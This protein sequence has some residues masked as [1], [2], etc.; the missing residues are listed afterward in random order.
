M[1]IGTEPTALMLHPAALQDLPEKFQGVFWFSTDPSP[2]LC[3]NF[4]GGAFNA[5]TR[6]P[7]GKGNEKCKK[8]RNEFLLPS[9]AYIS[10]LGSA[11]LNSSI[12]TVVT[13][14]LQQ[15]ML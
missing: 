8:G 7:L 3:L 1:V 12:S 15:E 9:L 5:A 2:E 6:R 13:S 10:C 14:K 4:Q 11:K